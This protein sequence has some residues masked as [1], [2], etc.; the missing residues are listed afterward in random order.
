MRRGF[1]YEA[2]LK[3]VGGKNLHTDLVGGTASLTVEK[4]V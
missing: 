1:G 2:E 3:E 4:Q